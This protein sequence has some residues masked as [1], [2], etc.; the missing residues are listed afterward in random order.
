M[1]RLWL[2]L[3]LVACSHPHPPPARD[4][5]ANT[6]PGPA[7]DPSVEKD[8][9]QIVGGYFSIDEIGP[10]AYNALV[11]RVKA[12]PAPYLDA[13]DNLGASTSHAMLVEMRPEALLAL[14][15]AYAPARTAQVARRLID[16]Y[17]AERI[18]NHVA[19]LQVIIDEVSSP[20]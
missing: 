1:R 18:D 14:T 19:S 16:R 17:D 12:D 2:L 10:D 9:E 6:V 4:P 13:L 3:A 20:R 8:V 5:V 11:R 15:R 7:I